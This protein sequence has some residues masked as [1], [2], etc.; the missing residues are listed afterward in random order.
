MQIRNELE[1]NVPFLAMLGPP[2]LI[3]RRCNSPYV[4]QYP[5]GFQ[6]P[7]LDSG[8]LVVDTGFLQANYTGS[9]VFYTGQCS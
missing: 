6:I 5:R 8:F 1:F 4:K 3:G 2:T 9:T 7:I